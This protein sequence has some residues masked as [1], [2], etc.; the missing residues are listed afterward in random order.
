MDSCELNKILG[1]VLG[2][3]LILLTLNI[4]A[5]SLFSPKAPE[6]PGYDIAV[7]EEAAGG[8]APAQKEPEVPIATLLA[9]ADL[10]RG[11]QATKVCHT[12]HTFE[13]GGPNK[14]GPNLYGIVNDEK[15]HGRGGFNF[16]NAMKAAGGKWTFDD[17]NKFLTSP[18]G[19]IP[20]TSMSF[21]GVS[22]ATQRA[23]IIAY[24]NSNSDNPAPLPQAAEAQPPA[25]GGQQPQQGGQ[26]PAQGG[27][28]QPA[29][30]QQGGQQQAPAQGGQ[31]PAA[32]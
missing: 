22:R 4:A 9:K 5:G 31:Q 15:G 16:S 25:D 18:R 24:L 30:A 8:G 27:Q 12:C 21:A 23:D 1:A 3:C 19:Y 10:K 32:K 7:P 2:T 17:L 29:P 20:G 6:K 14:V 13:K 11:E 28:Q 26:Q